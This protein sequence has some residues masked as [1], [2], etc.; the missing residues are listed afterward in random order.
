MPDLAAAALERVGE[1]HGRA[2]L[3]LADQPVGFEQFAGD[4]FHRCAGGPFDRQLRP[5]RRSSAPDR[6]RTRPASAA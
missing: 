3:R 6:R 4:H 2:G 1:P 5:A